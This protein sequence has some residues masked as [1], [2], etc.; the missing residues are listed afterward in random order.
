MPRL[1][2]NNGE[3]PHK[4][5]WRVTLGRKDDTRPNR[6]KYWGWWDG[7][8]WSTFPNQGDTAEVA[9]RMGC[10]H[11]WGDTDDISWTAAYPKNARVPRID[12]DEWHFNVGVQPAA[13]K[14]QLECMLFSGDCG[15]QAAAKWEWSLPEGKPVGSKET[16]FLI[17]A[18]RVA[19]KPQTR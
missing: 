5:W 7:V 1:K 3:P 14:V 2:W 13:D 9:G 16:P 11:G 6:L 17:Y 12:P 19:K 18:W 15:V 8:K 10:E 4:G